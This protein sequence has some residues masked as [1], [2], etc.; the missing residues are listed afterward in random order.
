MIRAETFLA[1]GIRVATVATSTHVAFEPYFVAFV[2][3]LLETVLADYARGVFLAGRAFPS[4]VAVGESLR[5]YT[6]SSGTLL[7]F[8]D[9]LFPVQLS[10][11]ELSALVEVVGRAVGRVQES[12]DLA[13]VGA[14]E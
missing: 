12:R 8:F 1:P 11:Q 13:R 3:A 10:E 5:A 6:F 2:V 14:D 4:H 9:S 7:Q